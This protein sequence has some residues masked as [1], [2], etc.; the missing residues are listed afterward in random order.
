MIGSEIVPFDG[1]L[2]K[3]ITRELNK[4]CENA[5]I[6]KVFMPERHEIVLA[7]RTYNDN[8][9]ISLNVNQ[10]MPRVHFTTQKKE[11]PGTPPMFCMLLRKH[12]TGGRILSVTTP[13]YERI[14][15]FE[16]E[17]LT[18]LGDVSVKKL[19]VEI[20]GKYS[21]I[22]L[23]NDKGVIIDSLR[24]V[25]Y[26][27]SSKREVMP[28][29][30]YELAPSQDKVSIDE[31]TSKDI[32]EAI[33]NSD[34]TIEKIILNLVLGFSPQ[35]S[36]ECCFRAGLDSK[37]RGVQLNDTEMKL[38]ALEVMKVVT[39]FKC[40][41]FVFA[42]YFDTNKIDKITDFYCMKLN[43]MNVANVF[44]TANEMLD[45]FFNSRSKEDKLNSLKS[46][47]V[48]ILNTNIERCV[49]KRSI[50]QKSIEDAADYEEIKKYGDL[51]TANIYM[52]KE[53]MKVAS[54]IDYFREDTPTID[55]PLQVNLPPQ[56]NA[57]KYYKIYNKKKS[58][59]EKANT[60][61]VETEQEIAYLESIVQNIDDCGNVSD[62]ALI[63]HEMI[64]SGY[65]KDNY[66]TQYKKQ[67][68]YAGKGKKV[69]KRVPVSRKEPKQSAPYEYTSSEGYKI[70]AGKNN[71]MNDLL[72]LKSSRGDDIWLHTQKIPGSHV[73][74]KCA[75]QNVS[76]KT[77]E[78]AAKI[79]V[80]HSRAKESN[81]VPV[82]YTQVKNVKKPQGAKPGMV[83]YDK[84][85]TIYVKI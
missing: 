38:L 34:K 77:I 18:E 83:I 81:N 15:M 28:A 68:Y 67:V 50:Q 57:Q 63:K 37:S 85:K 73:I 45:S 24:H 62:L 9:R 12:L 7:I 79:A 74:I 72:T 11:N 19:I 21:N 22:I 8:Y 41:N 29:R 26:S 44:G 78:E 33:Q 32:I 23:V 82:D 53:G 76:S 71:K 10:S 64:S 36:R 25:D 39:D 66:K 51:I 17:T 6:E 65:C 48:K 20:M 49:K 35:I 2:T 75:G 59:I 5:R 30:I 40:G 54:V 47:L 16:I 60:Q 70:Y 58:T 69:V 43:H 27:V 52:I 14:I 46:E 4:E 13:G 42:D 3:I 84:F 80:K 56:R 31:I 1:I 55:I 61:L